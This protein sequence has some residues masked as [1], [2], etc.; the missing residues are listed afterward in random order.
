MYPD[1]CHVIRI[2]NPQNPVL[3][4]DNH[5]VN[6]DICKDLPRAV[7]TSM[8]IKFQIN[9]NI[10]PPIKFGI[11][12]IVLNIF[13][14]F[15]PLVTK[16]A[17]LKPTK[18]IVN[19]EIFK[20]KKIHFIVTSHS[21]FILSDLPK[22][23]VIFLEKYNEENK[24]ENSLKDEEKEC[25]LGEKPEENKIH[26]SELF[27]NEEF[28]EEILEKKEK[29]MKKNKKIKKMKINDLRKIIREEIRN[30]LKEEKGE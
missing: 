28:L 8:N 9:P 18:F 7:N 22:E 23:N 11:K 3:V 14:P 6:Q 25:C 24:V 30:V 1:I 29:C 21:P 15:K 5:P 2:T 26:I 27:E 17:K 12:N 13:V 10:N 19:I 16:R 20:H 4:S